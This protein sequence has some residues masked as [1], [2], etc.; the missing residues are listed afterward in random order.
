L[1]EGAAPFMVSATA[2]EEN[3]FWLQQQNLCILGIQVPDI[4]PSEHKKYHQL[5]NI[6]E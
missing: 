3:K 1:E 6:D 2:G 4:C 5:L